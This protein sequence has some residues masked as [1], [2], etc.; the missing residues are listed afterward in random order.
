MDRCGGEGGRAE[1]EAVFVVS[2][3]KTS[4]GEGSEWRPERKQGLTMGNFGSVYLLAFPDLYLTAHQVSAICLCTA[5]N[6]S[7]TLFP[8]MA[9]PYVTTDAVAVVIPAAGESVRFATPLLDVLGASVIAPWNHWTAQETRIPKQYFPVQLAQHRGGSRTSHSRSKCDQVGGAKVRPSRAARPTEER[10]P[11]QLKAWGGEKKGSDP[12]PLTIVHD[13]A[14]PF[15]PRATTALLLMTAAE[16]GAAGVGVPL[17]STVLRVDPVD[18]NIVNVL[19]RSSEFMASEMPQVFQTD[20]LLA[21]YREASSDLLDHGTECLDLVLRQAGPGRVK[22]IEARGEERDLLFKVTTP[23]DLLLFDALLAVKEQ[24]RREVV[25]GR[26]CGWRCALWKIF[27]YCC[28][29]WFLF[30][31]TWRKVK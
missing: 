30:D 13:G 18:R 19:P 20:L 23:R 1:E 12:P 26:R 17:V 24:R 7:L 6:P 5:V 22:V 16:F 28:I 9:A 14:R 2:G 21:A 25:G 15:V 4:T 11:Q 31:W 10:K 29:S 27:G 3:G 8:Q